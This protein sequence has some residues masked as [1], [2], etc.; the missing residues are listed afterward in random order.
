[1]ERHFREVG[2]QVD[3]PLLRPCPRNGEA[4]RGRSA[5]NNQVTGMEEHATGGARATH[6]STGPDAGEERF[7][8]TKDA[9]FS[10]NTLAI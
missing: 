3:S 1:M 9:Y 5:L 6:D 2:R 10:R 8:P 4:R 7:R